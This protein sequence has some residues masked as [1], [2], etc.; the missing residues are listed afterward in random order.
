MEAKQVPVNTNDFTITMERLRAGDM[1][2]GNG[3]GT[4]LSVERMRNQTDVPPSSTD[5]SKANPGQNETIAADSGTRSS[6]APQNAGSG[7][8]QAPLK[9]GGLV[10]P[11][12]V[13][14]PP[15]RANRGFHAARLHEYPD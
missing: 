12:T 14:A 15:I 9:Q 1:G 3:A 4:V 5:T 8:D 7:T 2:A 6:L 10:V 11:E 13:G